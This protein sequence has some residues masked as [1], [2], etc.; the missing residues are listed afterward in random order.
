MRKR[1]LAL[2][3]VLLTVSPCI[4]AAEHWIR[5]TTPHFEMYTTNGVKPGTAALGVFEQVRYFFLQ[6][7]RSQSAPDT[8]VRIIAFKSEKEFQ[9]Y[10][11]NQ[12]AF[13]YYL[14]S[15]KVDYIV[16]QDISSEHHQAAVHEYTHLIV[17]HLGLKLPVWLNEGLADLYSTI[18]PKGDKSMIGRPIEGRM[19]QLAGQRW[20]DLPSLFAVT[21]DSPYYNERDKMSIF[22]AESWALTHMLAL[23]DS[24]RTDFPKFLAA[25]AANRS[26]AE[27]F[28][29]VYGKNLTQVNQDLQAYL[30]RSTVFVAVYDVKLSKSDLEPDVTELSD[31]NVD[32]ALANLLA[33]QKKK[34]PE[35]SERLSKLA[36][37]HPESSEV[38]ESLGYLAWQQGD[39]AKA[40]D[41]FKHALDKGSKNP[42]MMFH[43]AQLLR[44]S[45]TPASEIVPVLQHAVE[46]KPDYQDA[47]FNLGLTALQA[48]QPGLANESFAHIKKVNEEHA[49]TLF[50]AQA[51][52]Y[53]QLKAPG[54]AR[55]KALMAKRYAKGPEQESRI[56]SFLRQLD[57]SNQKADGLNSKTS[58]EATPVP[59]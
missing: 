12:G 58:V 49:F 26:A 20:L 39:S 28:Q 45:G 5:L 15:R 25:I 34:I 10:R 53:L 6:N 11:I 19:A 2:A 59:Q 3:S 44:N 14:R 52:C 1:L 38:D 13:A 35:A 51:Y 9:P 40:K 42:E 27:C 31:L 57:G 17:E 47:W 33:S 24:Y 32:L 29:S 7:S 46:I 56:D 37:E 30:K 50:F 48:R 22:Y 16:M 21:P 43:Y 55:E 41:D 18:E 54:Q 4:S 8:P 36:Q 23:G